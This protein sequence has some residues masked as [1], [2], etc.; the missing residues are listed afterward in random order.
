VFSHV[1]ADFP[2]G[3]LALTH[4]MDVVVRLTELSVPVLRMLSHDEGVRRRQV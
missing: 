3:R 1:V 2:I 4:V